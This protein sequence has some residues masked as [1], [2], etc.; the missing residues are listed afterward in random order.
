MALPQGKPSVALQMGLTV[1]DPAE[2]GLVEVALPC[3]ACGRMRCGLA[4]T[5]AETVYEF[6]DQFCDTEQT[7]SGAISL[8]VDMLTQTW[9]AVIFKSGK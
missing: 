4:D 7:V 3:C 1:F 2:S 9:G 8:W 5:A 6:Q